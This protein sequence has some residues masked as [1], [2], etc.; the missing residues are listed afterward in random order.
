MVSEDK[1]VL[2]GSPFKQ[3]IDQTLLSAKRRE[4]TVSLLLLHSLKPQQ[5]S[6]IRASKLQSN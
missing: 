3:L 1:A 2:Q 4:L 5:A 6:I